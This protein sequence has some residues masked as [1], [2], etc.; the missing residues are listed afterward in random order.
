MAK[1]GV[2][3]NSAIP[4]SWLF[5]LSVAVA[6]SGCTSLGAKTGERVQ[7]NAT[8]RYPMASLLGNVFKATS[9]AR[10]STTSA[11]TAVPSVSPSRGRALTSS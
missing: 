9:T 1:E 4:W 10:A 3:R 5:A 8:A 6:L 7:L 2:M 11:A